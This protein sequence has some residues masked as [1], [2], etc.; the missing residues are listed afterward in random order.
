MYTS[1]WVLLEKKVQLKNWSNLR[2][3]KPFFY[4]RYNFSYFSNIFSRARVAIYE[5]VVYVLNVRPCAKLVP[6]WCHYGLWQYLDL[7]S[8]SDR[9]IVSHPKLRTAQNRHWPHLQ[10][11]QN[12]KIG[13]SGGQARESDYLILLKNI[14]TI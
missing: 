11:R 10:Y 13:H 3:S 2:F 5:N 14:Y 1:I 12:T 8:K 6:R 7:A 4:F 9:S